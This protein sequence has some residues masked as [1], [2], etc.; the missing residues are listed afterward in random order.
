MDNTKGE[1]LAGGFAQVRLNA[2]QAQAPLAVPAN[3][4]LFRTEGAFVAV[5]GAD[6]HLT[7]RRVELGRDFGT[8]VELL[9]GVTPSDHLVLNPADSLVDGME[10]RLAEK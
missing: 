2:A 4:L 10:V 1:L 3:T 9:S 8:E 6:N 7:L 5:V